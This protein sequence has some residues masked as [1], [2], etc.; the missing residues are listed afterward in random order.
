MANEL[1]RRGQVVQIP[2]YPHDYFFC[3][4]KTCLLKRV[5]Q[6]LDDWKASSVGHRLSA[7]EFIKITSVKIGILIT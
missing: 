3:N 6:V 5:T 7:S 2:C 4:R 1:L